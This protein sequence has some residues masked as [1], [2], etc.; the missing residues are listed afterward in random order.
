MEYREQGVRVGPSPHGLGVFS[1]R[2]LAPNELLGPI[3]G[4]IID[5]K[6]YESDYCI[7]LGDGW[8]LEPDSPFRYLNHSCHPNCALLEL[9]CEGG[10]ESTELWLKVETVVAPGEQ[11]TIDYSWPAETAPPCSCGC[12]DCR[13]WIVAAEELDQVSRGLP[14]TKPR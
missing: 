4:M 2:V 1:L 5:D 10:N 12:P 7:E 3:E 6:E 13:H 8:A 9:D 11:L 14:G